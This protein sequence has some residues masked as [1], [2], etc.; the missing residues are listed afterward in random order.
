MGSGEGLCTVESDKNRLLSG[1]QPCLLAKIGI[2]ELKIQ[3]IG[4]IRISDISFR[5][6]YADDL[7]S[8][9]SL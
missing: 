4:P 2:C 9:A 5:G 3:E 7:Q 6:N 8:G 1:D